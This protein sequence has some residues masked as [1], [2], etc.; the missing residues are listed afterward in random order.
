MKVILAT[1]RSLT[2]ITI[3]EFKFTEKYQ[4]RENIILI[5]FYMSLFLNQLL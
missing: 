1:M 2:T 3:D 5:K 4:K